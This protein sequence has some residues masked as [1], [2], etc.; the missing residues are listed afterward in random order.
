[1]KDKPLKQQQTEALKLI[2]QLKECI[3]EYFGK[4]CE[5]QFVGC[6]CCIAWNAIRNLE[7]IFDV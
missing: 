7:Q 6:F 2:E 4:E 3:E 5:E 1:M